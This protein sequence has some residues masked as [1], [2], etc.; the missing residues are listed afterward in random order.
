MRN[1]RT[2]FVGLNIKSPEDLEREEIAK[3]EVQDE[4]NKAFHDP[5]DS[6]EFV[7][8]P[9]SSGDTIESE[10]S[11]E[12]EEEIDIP[13]ESNISKTLSD[14]TTKTVVLLVLFLLVMQSACNTSTYIDV[15][16]VHK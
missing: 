13:E 8:M 11:E 7:S 2:A 3:Q 12:E 10:E 15:V 16:H 14:A 4:K 9:S 6:D 1:Q 5:T